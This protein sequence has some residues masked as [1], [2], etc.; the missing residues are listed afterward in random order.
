MDEVVKHLRMLAK[1]GEPRNKDH[2]LCSEIFAS[3]G[4]PEWR[5]IR[6]HFSS[7]EHFSGSRDF[8]VPSTHKHYNALEYYMKF[9]Q[10]WLRKQGRLRRD[11]CT[12]IADQLEK[13]YA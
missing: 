5:I 10:K 3:F 12:H 6:P 4:Q 13:E 7:W 11:L 9:K 2:G 8:P 1:G